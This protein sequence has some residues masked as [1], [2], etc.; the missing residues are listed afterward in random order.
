[1]FESIGRM[2]GSLDIARVYDIRNGGGVAAATFLVDRLWPRGVSKA[3]LPLTGWLKELTPSDQLRRDFHG[4]ALDWGQFGD[5]YR[6]ELDERHAD[7]ALDGDL[8]TLAQELGHRDVLL[9]FAGKDTEHTHARVLR[10]WLS[11]HLEDA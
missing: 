7:G 2:M 9:L 11:G 4:G 6:S 3:S 1:M 8:A 5:A 10:E